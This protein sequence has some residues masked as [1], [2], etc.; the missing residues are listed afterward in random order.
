MHLRHLLYDRAIPVTGLPLETPG[1]P[2]SLLPHEV[3]MLE[4]PLAVRLFLV[5]N[6]VYIMIKSVIN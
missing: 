1:P 4:P 3:D 6:G 2:P 5:V